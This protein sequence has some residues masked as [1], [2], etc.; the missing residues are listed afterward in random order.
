MRGDIFAE[1]G[2]EREE[3]SRRWTEDSRQRA[4]CAHRGRAG[5]EIGGLIGLRQWLETIGVYVHACGGQRSVLGI[6]C[7]PS[8]CVCTPDRSLTEPGAHRL[9]KLSS[10]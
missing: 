2:R 6:Y 5:E 3:L 1:N 10:Q 8:F 4:S 7:S 9:V